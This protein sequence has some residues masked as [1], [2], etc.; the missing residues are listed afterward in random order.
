MD[1]H[2]ERLYLLY[3]SGADADPSGDLPNLV[4][5]RN[6]DI[7][8]VAKA[9][10]E[11]LTQ[12]EFEWVSDQVRQLEAARANVVDADDNVIK[13]GITKRD[14]NERIW[15]IPDSF[16]QWKKPFEPKRT[17]DNEPIE[18]A[19][20][21]R[22]PLESEKD[23]LGSAAQMAAIATTAINPEAIWKSITDSA[24]DSAAAS[25]AIAPKPKNPT[26]LASLA[27]AIFPQPKEDR[28]L[29]LKP[30]AK[31]AEVVAPPI[32][33]V[34]ATPAKS[35]SKV[36]KSI[37]PQ[38]VDRDRASPEDKPLRAEEPV[39]IPPVVPSQPV[40]TQK[41]PIE[42]RSESKQTETVR[43]RVVPVEA[44]PV[45]D[46]T[47]L[48]VPQMQPATAKEP[49]R[50]AIPPVLPV[51]PTIAAHHTVRAEAAQPASQRIPPVLPQVTRERPPIEPTEERKAVVE[52]ARQE[53]PQ[54]ASGQETE[55]PASSGAMDKI[56]AFLD[57]AGVVDPTP[58]ADGANTVISLIRAVGD[59]KN[60][61]THLTNA[62][63]SAV[64]VI[65]YVGDIAKAFKY[66]GK[67]ADAT[68]AASTAGKA[69]GHGGGGIAGAIQTAIGFAGQFG[70]LGGGGN[71]GGGAGG[72]AGGGGG[73]GGAGGGS[74]GGTSGG[75]G[76]GGFSW[77][78]GAMWLAAGAF[79]AGSFRDTLHKFGLFKELVTTPPKYTGD[80]FDTGKSAIKNA[81]KID[82]MMT[83]FPL[84]Y[85]PMAWLKK[86][87]F[88]FAEKFVGWLQEVEQAGQKMLEHNRRLADY[89]GTIAN[90]FTQLDVDRMK[91]DILRGKA[92]AGDV[93][94]LSEAQSDFEAAKQDLFMPFER[95]QM[96]FQTGLTN[97]GTGLMKLIDR[98]EPITEGV[99]WWLGQAKSDSAR[100]SLEAA[101]QDHEKRIPDRL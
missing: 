101:I 79:L 32:H 6:T 5:R 45:Q 64:S 92:T 78:N 31:Q 91:R 2:D 44:P 40:A 50:P 89:N 93:K 86:K 67:A 83:P 33:P 85:T 34:A 90:A 87:I 28:F 59:P 20:S 81:S 68:K 10:G 88:G 14:Y 35:E 55:Q 16:S 62:A 66:G 17:E 65:P 13:R 19:E 53:A 99:N 29:P 43:E 48:R 1:L 56:Q 3:Q 15:E 73:S 69:A 47:P 52:E 12:E 4:W 75:P 18:D 63:T 27:A 97:L 30:S 41:P 37:Q 23:A 76:G 82:D 70:G 39:K 24:F 74:G 77:G 7:L 42:P 96:N 26:S 58:I 84:N 25:Q 36:E 11:D 98:V 46:S 38:P 49:E 9:V 95:L 72:N 51:A 8:Q 94:G 54:V 71:A 100:S 61:G 80:A 60:A 21:S 22:K 57:I